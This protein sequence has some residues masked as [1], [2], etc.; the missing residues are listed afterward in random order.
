[1]SFLDSLGDLA[2]DSV[3]ATRDGRGIRALECPDW[4]SHDLGYEASRNTG[5]R[6]RCPRRR[7]LGAL[8]VQGDTLAR[9]QD[10]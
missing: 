7:Y 8:V 10:V 4:G 3:G 1:M 2:C 5:Q 6:H 9:D